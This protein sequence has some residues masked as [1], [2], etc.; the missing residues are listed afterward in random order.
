LCEK[1]LDD[2]IREPRYIL[3]GNGV[4]NLYTEDVEVRAFISRRGC[5][6]SFAD[7]MGE[8]AGLPSIQPGDVENEAID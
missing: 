3:P 1:R 2:C 6:Q 4:S 7:A 5:S 8:I